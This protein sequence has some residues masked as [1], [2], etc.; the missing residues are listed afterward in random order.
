MIPR[1]RSSKLKSLFDHISGGFWDSPVNKECL[2]VSELN[3]EEE[4]SVCCFLTI[5]IDVCLVDVRAE[6]A[7]VI[8]ESNSYARLI[9]CVF[10]VQANVEHGFR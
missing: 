3:K 2:K 1:K 4:V 9:C 7:F 5:V 8:F 10:T 6:L